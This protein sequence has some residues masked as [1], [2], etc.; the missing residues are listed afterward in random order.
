MKSRTESP[1]L[2]GNIFVAPVAA[3]AL[4]IPDL[5]A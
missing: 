1:Y 3:A 2:I 4:A 5:T